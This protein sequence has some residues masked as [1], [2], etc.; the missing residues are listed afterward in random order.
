[1]GHDRYGKSY[2]MVKMLWEDSDRTSVNMA[3]LDY[4]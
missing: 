3:A 2:G 4:P 1:M